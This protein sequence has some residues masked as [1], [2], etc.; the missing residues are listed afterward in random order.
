M[1]RKDPLVGLIVGGIELTGAVI[2]AAGSVVVSVIEGAKREKAEQERRKVIE[3]ITQIR[4]EQERIRHQQLIEKIAK[5]RAQEALRR[6]KKELAEKRRCE[7]EELRRQMA[8]EK[9]FLS[10]GENEYKKRCTEREK[11][12]DKFIKLTFK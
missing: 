3:Q 12:V 9:K 11:I 10:D 8:F 7:R 2:G 1:G 4:N 5:K 6:E